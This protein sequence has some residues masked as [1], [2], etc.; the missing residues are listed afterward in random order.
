[1]GRKYKNPPIIEALCEFRFDP[2]SPWDL[3]IPGRLH[4]R[5]KDAFPTVRQGKAFESSIRA[6]PEGVRQQLIETERG[7]FLRAD[8]KALVQVGPHLLVINHLRPYPTWETFLPLIDSTL[9]AYREVAHPKAF[10]RIGLRYVNRVDFPSAAVNLEDY[11]EFYPFVGPELPQTFGPFMVGIQ[12]PYDGGRDVLKLEMTTV[13]AEAPAA[14]S[15]VLSL[16]YFLARPGEVDFASALQW[17]RDAHER[18]ECVFEGSIKDALRLQ[19]E[20]I[21]K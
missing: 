4:E 6:G 15:F 10:Q 20:E 18:I 21:R 2:A 16:D 5:I 13:A 8:E 3:T 14:A 1:M 11:F 12:I 17:V 7:Q 9:E 19:F